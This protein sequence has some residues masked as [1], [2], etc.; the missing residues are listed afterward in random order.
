LDRDDADII[1]SQSKSTADSQRLHS[2]RPNRVSL[3]RLNGKLWIT[4]PFCEK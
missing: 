3:C 4:T 1:L 2:D